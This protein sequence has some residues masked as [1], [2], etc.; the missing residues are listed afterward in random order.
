MDDF[1][2]G[3]EGL[4]LEK[5]QICVDRDTLMTAREGVFAGGDAA[6]VGFYTAIEAVAAGRRGA[7]SIHNFLRGER[8]LP[9]WDDERAVAR[10]TD[11]ELAAIDVGQRVPMRMVDG[12]QRRADWNEVEPRL[13]RRGGRGR[14]RALPQLRRLQRVRQ[15]RARLSRAARS[16]GTRRRPSRR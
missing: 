7:A 12:L 14:G 9:V 3:C 8:L 4:T 11:E 2:R 16:T 6:A 5:G 13:L 1:A 15:L 10:P